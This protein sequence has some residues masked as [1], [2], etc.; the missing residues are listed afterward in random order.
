MSINKAKKF[1]SC[2][3]KLVNWLKNLIRK[4]YDL[5]TVEEGFLCVYN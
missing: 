5:A 2:T 4:G 3:F 1:K